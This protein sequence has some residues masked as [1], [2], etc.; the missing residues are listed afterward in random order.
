MEPDAYGK[1]NTIIF[2]LACVAMTAIYYLYCEQQKEAADRFQ[3]DM[4][5]TY[6]E[7]VGEVANDN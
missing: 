3:K 7:R 2:L 1:A 6:R 5:A 4:L